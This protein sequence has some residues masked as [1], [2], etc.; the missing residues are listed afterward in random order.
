MPRCG[1]DGKPPLNKHNKTFIKAKL[2]DR[3]ELGQQKLLLK[4]KE[5]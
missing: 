4:K 3:I 1:G 2:R 5:C